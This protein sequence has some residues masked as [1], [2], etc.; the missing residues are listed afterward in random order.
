MLVDHQSDDIPEALFIVGIRYLLNNHIFR[1]QM[2]LTLQPFL[3]VLL[4]KIILVNFIFLDLFQAYLFFRVDLLRSFIMFC[5]FVMFLFLLEFFFLLI[6]S[7]FLIIDNT[8][9]VIFCWLWQFAYKVNVCR[10]V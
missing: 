2:P 8:D 10:A 6:F 7:L 9:A 5:L 3:E 1:I 4:V